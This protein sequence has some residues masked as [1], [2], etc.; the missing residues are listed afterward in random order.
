M[1]KADF[2]RVS[3]II[4]AYNRYSLLIEAI[5]SVRAQTFTDYELLIVDDGSTD[6]TP[7]LANELDI[8]YMSPTRTGMPGASRNR[9]AE[10]ARG[11]YL[12]FLDSD[13]LWL[14]EKLEKQVAVLDSHAEIPLVHTRELWKRGEKTV[15]Q[16]GQNHRRE[17]DV[18]RDAL[19]KCTIGPSTVLMRKGVFMELG[20]FDETLEVAEDYEFWLRLTS[21]YPVFYIDEALT[22]KRAGGWDQLSE[23]YGQIEEFRIEALF[24]LL[25]NR[26]LSESGSWRLLQ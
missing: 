14:P 11:E 19:W 6:E 1:I 25:E 4:P 22:V 21:R 8:H 12:G 3:V 20:G 17:G 18:F 15:S 9:G 24:R 16:K 13:D 7:A 10:A 5:E 2:P 23:K 26:R